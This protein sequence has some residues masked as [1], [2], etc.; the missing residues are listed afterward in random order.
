[1][2]KTN[3]LIFGVVLLLSG[4]ALWAYGYNLEPTVGE[5]ISNVFDGDFTDK[6]N[7]LMFAGGALAVVGAG[8]LVGGAFTGGGR[9]RSA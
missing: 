6:R 9:L 7:I 8:T 1:M 4:V 2:L 5:A 3:V